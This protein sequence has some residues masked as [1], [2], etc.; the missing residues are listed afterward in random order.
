MSMNDADKCPHCGG[1]L[2]VTDANGHRVM[3]GAPRRTDGALVCPAC[4]KILTMTGQ[5]V[6]SFLQFSSPR[7]VS[8]ED[9]DAYRSMKLSDAE[10]DAILRNPNVK[11]A[12]Q[13]V[14]EAK[15]ARLREHFNGGRR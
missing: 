7:A 8:Q 13:P 3:F 11:I 4:K 15:I 10:V 1:N 2:T 6:A 14:D 9:A 12:L 5:L